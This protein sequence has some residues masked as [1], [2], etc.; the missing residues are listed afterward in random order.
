[1]KKLLDV[2]AVGGNVLGATI[3]AA[4]LDY[5]AL[6]YLSFLIGSICAVVLLKQSNVRASMMYLHIFY[7]CINVVGMVRYTLG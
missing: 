4:N 7:V 5:N 2:G 6:G 1:V 3:V